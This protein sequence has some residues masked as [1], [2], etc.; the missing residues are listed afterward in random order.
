MD[1]P[2]KC[3][4]ILKIAKI[5]TLLSSFLLMTFF[6]ND[7]QQFNELCCIN[8]GTYTGEVQESSRSEA[9][10]QVEKSFS[11]NYGFGKTLKEKKKN[12]NI[13]VVFYLEQI[14]N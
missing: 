5:Y 7:F 4:Y 2:Y 8:E 12:Y 6:I 1:L 9:M 13:N 14:S 11:E 10:V 3:Q